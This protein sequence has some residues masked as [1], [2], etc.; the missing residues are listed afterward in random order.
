MTTICLATVQ[1]IWMANKHVF[2]RTK[3][4]GPSLPKDKGHRQKKRQPLFK[5]LSF[6]FCS[7]NGKKPPA[8]P[9]GIK[10]FRYKKASFCSTTSGFGNRM[11]KEALSL[12]EINS[13]AHVTRDSGICAEY[14]P[15]EICRMPVNI[16]PGWR[17]EQ[18]ME[19][20]KGESRLLIFD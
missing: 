11:Q 10:N 6:L 12:T 9:V 3:A 15:Y 18:F 4:F 2:R 8:M 1:P 16:L 19:Y 5:R 20:Q 13:L 7:F 17:L 14:W